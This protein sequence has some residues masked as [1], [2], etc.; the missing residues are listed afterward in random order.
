MA[1]A[2]QTWDVKPNV[3]INVILLA[4]PVGIICVETRAGDYQEFILQT[5]DAMTVARVFQLVLRNDIEG[6]RP[7]VDYLKRGYQFRKIFSEVTTANQE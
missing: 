5:S 6:V 1:A 4:S 2:V 7:V 3:Q